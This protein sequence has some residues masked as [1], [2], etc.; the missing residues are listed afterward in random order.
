MHETVHTG[1]LEILGQRIVGPDTTPALSMLLG[2][3]MRI[4][5]V[6]FD[7]GSLLAFF[8]KPYSRFPLPGTDLDDGAL[9]CLVLR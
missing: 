8:S 4:D 1:V 6:D 9:A 5:R 3:G 7:S 2:T